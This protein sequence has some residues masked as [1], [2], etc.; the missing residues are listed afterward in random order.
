MQGIAAAYRGIV[1]T[2]AQLEGLEAD[3]Q[4]ALQESQEARD[5]LAASKAELE[6]I[7]SENQELKHSLAASELEK[8]R[9]ENL[10]LKNSLAASRT[11]LEVAKAEVQASQAALKDERVVSEQSLQDLFYHCWSHNPDADFSFMP[12][13]LWAFLLP[14]LQAHLNKE[15]PH[16]RLERPLPRRSR[17]RPRPPKGQL[18]GLRTLLV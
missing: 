12:P 18:R 11:D 7:R 2:K 9:S 4:T 15:V 3:R 13:D 1:R 17:M 14:Q 8:L 5:A 16:R 6:K 10:E